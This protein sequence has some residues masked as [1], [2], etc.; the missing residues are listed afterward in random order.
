M[1]QFLIGLGTSLIAIP[2]LNANLDRKLNN[3]L[4]ELWYVS[5]IIAHITVHSYYNI[6]NNV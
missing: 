5:P 4:G 3:I 6:I 1:Q 2:F